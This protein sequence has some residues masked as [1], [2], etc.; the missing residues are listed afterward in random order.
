[1][2]TEEVIHSRDIINSELLLLSLIF[3]GLLIGFK[4]KLTGGGLVCT[5]LVGYTIWYWI[6]RNMLASGW[7]WYLL[8]SLPGGLIIALSGYEIK[9]NKKKKPKKSRKSAG[10]SKDD[11][12][13]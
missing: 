2:V 4:Y 1:M 5:S 11:T 8:I 9:L 13:K 10:K 12:K 3:I 6:N 7:L